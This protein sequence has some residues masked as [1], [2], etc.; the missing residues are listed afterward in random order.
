MYGIEFSET[1]EK[2]FFN[3]PPE[4]QKRLV[5]VLERI[6]IRPFH[7]IKRKEGSNNFILRF[8]EYRAILEI[9]NESKIIYIIDAGHRKTIY[10]K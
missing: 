2:Q 7:F 8:G 1:G 5:N 10:K 9:D 4:N 6:K 3:L